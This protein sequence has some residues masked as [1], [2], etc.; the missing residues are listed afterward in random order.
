MC[1]RKSKRDT[2]ENDGDVVRPSYGCFGD[3]KIIQWFQ[4]TWQMG[5]LHGVA[6]IVGLLWIGGFSQD[7]HGISILRIVS[8]ETHLD[9]RI[10]PLKFLRIGSP[11]C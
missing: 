1:K 11:R 8:Y 7:F 5:Q 10:G 6:S 3:R 4:P 2:K 9:Q